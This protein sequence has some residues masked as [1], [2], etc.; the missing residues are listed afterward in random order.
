MYPPKLLRRTISLLVTN[1]ELAF[2]DLER[3]AIQV[4]TSMARAIQPFAT[5]NDGDVLYAATT[6]E[7]ENP[8]PPHKSRIERQCRLSWWKATPSGPRNLGSSRLGDFSCL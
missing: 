4:H 7:V 3:L 8:E 2:S 6:G 1:Q 5:T